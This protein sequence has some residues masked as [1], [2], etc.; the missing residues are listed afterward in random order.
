MWRKISS[1]TTCVYDAEDDLDLY[2]GASFT[3]GNECHFS[4]RKYNG[5]PKDT[6]TLYLPSTMVDIKNVLRSVNEIVNALAIPGYAI[7]WK[8]GMKFE[9]GK[10]DRAPNDR[11]REPE[12]RILALKIAAQQPDRYATTEF[13][14][15]SIVNYYP[16]SD[17]DLIPSVPR[18]PEPHWE[19]IVRNVISHKSNPRGPFALGFAERKKDGLQVTD[20]GVDYLKSLGFFCD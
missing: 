18:H 15:N 8:R 11:L 17:I 12:A 3:I 5:H 2:V 9:Y 6:C 13:I 19:Q 7:A 16:L 10:L 14:K 1:Y 20:A 4:L